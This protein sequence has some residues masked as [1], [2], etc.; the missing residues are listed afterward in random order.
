VKGNRNRRRRRK[1]GLEKD[2]SISERKRVIGYDIGKDD[3][4]VSLHMEI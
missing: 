2:M 1:I 3:G 4:R